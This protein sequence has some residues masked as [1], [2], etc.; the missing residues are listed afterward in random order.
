[1]YLLIKLLGSYLIPG[2]KVAHASRPK[3]GHIQI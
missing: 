3:I 1:M 2:R